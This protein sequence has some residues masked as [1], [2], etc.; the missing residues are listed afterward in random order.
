MRRAI[1]ARAFPLGFIT[2]LTFIHAEGPGRDIR[3]SAP[4]SP[5][6]RT[7]TREQSAYSGPTLPC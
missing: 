6:P 1:R 5:L 3:L 7:L 2:L 4:P